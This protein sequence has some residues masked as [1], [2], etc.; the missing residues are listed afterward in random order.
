MLAIKELR[1]MFHSKMPTAGLAVLLSALA[2]SLAASASDDTKTDEK[3]AIVLPKD[4]KAVVISYDP[5]A[6]GFVRKGPA[7][8]LRI[9]A[10]GAVVVTNLFNGA[11][12]ESNLTPM[13]LKELLRFI[14]KENDFFALSAPKIA[15]DIKTAAGK[16]PFIAI[17]GAGTSVV[18]IRVNGKKH[19]VSYRGASAYL[20][21]YPKVKTLA[22][23][24]AVE[25]RLSDLGRSVEK[26]K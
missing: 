6:G 5:G 19:E 14:V 13:Q 18:N 10:D 7:P 9:H 25:K 17:G 16:G 21:V 24:V 22:Q 15:D 8:Y 20:R 4:P 2:I 3:S 26:G 23:F 1:S 11:K 12:K